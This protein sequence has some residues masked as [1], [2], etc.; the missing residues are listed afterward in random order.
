MSEVGEVNIVLANSSNILQ[1]E[2]NK[3]FPKNVSNFLNSKDINV[4]LLTSNNVANIKKIVESNPDVVFVFES[5]KNIEQLK[6]N[7]G[8]INRLKKKIPDTKIAF[9]LADSTPNGFKIGLLKRGVD[10]CI[11]YSQ[12]NNVPDILKSLKKGDSINYSEV[13]TKENIK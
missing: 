7:F 4:S 3:K 5:Y 11:P 9:F 1:I 10:V 6:E 2:E 8:F 12:L 13:L